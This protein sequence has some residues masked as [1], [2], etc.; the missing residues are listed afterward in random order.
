MPSIRYINQSA[1]FWDFIANME[2]QGQNHPFFSGNNNNNNNDNDEEERGPGGGRPPPFSPWGWGHPGMPFHGRG[3]H[4]GPPPPPEAEPEKPRK[5]PEQTEGERNDN[6]EGPSNSSDNEDCPRG[7]WGGWGHGYGRCEAGRGRHGSGP[8]GGRGF[9]RHGHHGGPY[10]GRHGGWGSWGGRGWGGPLNPFNF[11]DTNN[12]NVN[13]DKDFEPEADVFD[14]DS[15]FIIHVSLPGAKKEDV[16]VNWDAEKSELSIAGVIYRPGDEEFLKT[17]AMDERKVGPFERKV[18]LGTRANPA[19]V[20]ADMITA[21]LEDGVLKV[22][23]PKID[24][25]FVEVRKVD[26]Q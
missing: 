9:G 2:Q 22:E 26:I 19:Q 24:T 10:H 20:D 21:K 18:R 15:S 23:V 16:G 14:T 11:F 4:R 5:N 25:G 7:S 1:P 12:A 8:H 17:L 3:H 6:G 13:E